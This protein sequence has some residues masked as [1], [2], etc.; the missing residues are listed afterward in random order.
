MIGWI[1]HHP[2]YVQNHL[3]LR[4]VAP[5]TPQRVFFDVGC[6]TAHQRCLMLFG[7]DGERQMADACVAQRPRES[8]VLLVRQTD[9]RQIKR[10][11]AA[12]RDAQRHAPTPIIS[13]H[14]SP[15]WANRMTLFS[16]A[17]E[18][19]ALRWASATGFTAEVG[20]HACLDIK[21]L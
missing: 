15:R 3:V 6:H 1:L 14:N 2:L 8:A 9:A 7:A 10:P 20:G 19:E 18:E 12:T 21:G 4:G 13:L 5:E 16:K 11:Q 17:E